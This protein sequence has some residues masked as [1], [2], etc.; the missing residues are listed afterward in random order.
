MI[1][2]NNLQSLNSQRFTLRDVAAIA[3]RYRRVIGLC[4][5]GIIFGGVLSALMLP[6]YRAETKI[7]VTRGRVDPVVAPLPEAHNPI[8]NYE[9]TPEQIN[10]EVEL[11][12]SYDL[13]RKVVVAR[14]LH[15]PKT[16]FGKLMAAPLTWGL[17]EDQRIDK[18]TIKLAKAIDIQAVPK[19]NV[20]QITLTSSDPQRAAGVLANLNSL[21]L[22]K[23]RAVH[24]ASGQFNFFETQ[25]QL[26]RNS[27]PGL[28]TPARSRRGASRRFL[29]ERR[30]GP[31]NGA[32]LD[33]S[34]TERIQGQFAA[35][36]GGTGGSPTTYS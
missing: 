14:E 32:R 4:F 10:S 24:R 3:F 26:F 30:S 7:L 18:A 23:H 35:D 36:P 21:Y 11:L 34:A 17:T 33:R 25:T 27:D 20:I 1:E 13:L 22:D 9:L 29:P 5:I 8:A 31:A 12:N 6:K 16:S 15:H 28:Q 19:T 2:D